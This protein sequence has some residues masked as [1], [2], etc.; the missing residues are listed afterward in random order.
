MEE[1]DMELVNQGVWHIWGEI[2]ADQAVHTSKFILTHMHKP[3]RNL[4]HLTFII[5]SE[6]G[7]LAHAFAIIDLMHY[8]RLPVRTLGVGEISSAGL[9]IFMAGELGHRCVTANTQ[10]MSHQ[11][12]TQIQGKAYELLSAQQDMQITQAR[13]LAHYVKHTHKT[14][15]EVQQ[16]LLPPH[17]VYLTAAQA[18]E[19]GI[20]DH[21]T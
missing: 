19:L 13:V 9:M 10:I 7:D 2:D 20:A 17:D 21:V 5:N 1:I 11:W 8:S 12:S 16:L 6:G 18:V 15:S 14:E 4:K 3:R